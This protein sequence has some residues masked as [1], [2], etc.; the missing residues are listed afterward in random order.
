MSLLAIDVI[1]ETADPAEPVAAGEAGSELGL[2]S[3][4]VKLLAFFCLSRQLTLY[5]GRL[6]ILDRDH[7]VGSGA[8]RLLTQPF[9]DLVVAL[10]AQAVVE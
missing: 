9:H 7:H 3:A 6:A 2:E 5:D 8:L 10:P 4:R 1:E